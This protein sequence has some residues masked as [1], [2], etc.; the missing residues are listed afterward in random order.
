MSYD[1]FFSGASACDHVQSFER[2][3]IDPVDFRTLKL[4]S[5]PV[6]TMRAPINGQNFV[7]VYVGGTQIQPTDPAYGYQFLLDTTRLGAE[8]TKDIFYKIV[9]NRPVRIVVPLIEVTYITQQQYCLKCSGFG[10]LN[11]FKKANSG[12]LT[13][14]IGT[15]KLVQRSLKYILTSRCPFYP[16]F[17][18]AIKDYIGKKF[19]VVVTDADVANEVSRALQSFKQVQAAQRTVQTL[20][21]REILKDITSVSAIQDPTDPTVVVVSAQVSSYGST[22]TQPLTFALK[23]TGN[24]FVQ[25]QFSAQALNQFQGNQ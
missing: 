2:Y 12:S 21:P 25:G 14:I 7:K 19:G 24:T 9:F 20:D 22:L 5:S 17:T 10:R 4:A 13:H 11:D 15:N 16:Q 23:T 1:F 3:V 6:Q 8:L 18:C